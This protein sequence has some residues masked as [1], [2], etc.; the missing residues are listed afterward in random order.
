MRRITAALLLIALIA[1]PGCAADEPVVVSREALGTVVSI[2]AYG[3]DEAAVR[4]AIDDAFAVMAEI[5]APLDVYEPLSDISAFNERPYTA[6]PLP[7]YARDV[8]DAIDEL[9]VAD[10]FSPALYSVTRLYDFEGAQ[11]VPAEADIALA[12]TAAD[13]FVQQEPEHGLFARLKDPDPRLEPG[14][15][16]APGLDLGGAAKGLALDFARESLRANDAV[17]AALISSGS[18]TVTLGAKPDGSVWRV[19]IEDP[20]DFSRVIAVVGFEGDGALSTS[21][22]YQRYFEAGG[23]RYH[24]I[25]DP[26]NGLPARGVRSLTVAGSS[27]SGL[28]SDILS[29]A[30]FVR[31]PE[32]ATRYA[33]EHG[34]A[35][36]VV[37]DEGRTLVVPAPEGSG[38]TVA[39]DSVETD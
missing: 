37:D 26:T 38:L 20:R 22:D 32:R 15:S 18:S 24:H 39:E 6:Q 4:T 7:P 5:G 21:G 23:E 36:V 2:T 14:G 10:A 11:T 35:L 9:E 8:L 31:G 16:L 13:G 29:T 30:L 28:D 1:L 33:A 25:L 3:E 34:V 27:L 12:L 19:G 17:T